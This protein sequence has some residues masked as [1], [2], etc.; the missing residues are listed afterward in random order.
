M[1]Q[2]SQQVPQSESSLSPRLILVCATAAVGGFLFGYD[3]SVINGAVDALASAGSGFGLSSVMSGFSVSC[4]LIGCVGGAWLAG[5]LADRAG[6][7]R[8]MQLAAILFV[9]SAVASGFASNFAL[10][11]IARIIGGAGVGFT[12]AIGPAYISEISPVERRGFLASF[13][14][15]AI[16][17]GITASLVV[18]DIYATLSGGAAEPFW[19]GADTWRWMLVTTAVPGLI[20]FFLAFT[21]PES[22]RYL[23][24]RGDR[25]RAVSVLRD[26]T[27]ERNPEAVV[28]SIAATVQQEVGRRPKLSDLRGRTFGLKQVVWVGIGVA[29]FQQVS[30]CNVIMFYDSSLWQMVGFS[31]QQALHASVIR[32]LLTIVFTVIGMVFIDRI[33]RRALLRVGSLLMAIF[34]VVIAIGFSQGTVSADNSINLPGPWAV[35]VI[36][37]AYTFFMMYCATWGVAMWVVIGEIFPNSIRALGVALATAANW[38]GNFLVTTSFP[39]LRDSIGLPTT[40]VIYAAMALLGY[41]FVRRYL[42]ETNGVAL[43]NMQAEGAVADNSR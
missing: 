35:I 41:I 14:Q 37:S 30:G 1:R 19:A 4:A 39:P 5:P 21:L 20:M 42:P 18:N 3:T 13:Q 8:V 27:G 16:V 17:L 40:Y 31:E 36:V 33:G 2:Q 32:S 7:V 38:V 10:F 23:V 6:R 25:E 9:I 12:S 11:V 28:A 34:L 15:L 29:I 24:M 43:E 26:V 22:P